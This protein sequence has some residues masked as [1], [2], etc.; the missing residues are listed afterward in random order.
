MN[1][2][3]EKFGW[4]Y[5]EDNKFGMIQ[6]FWY[7]WYILKKSFIKSLYIGFNKYKLRRIYK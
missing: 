3:I 4:K 7:N 2:Y 1:K 6:E 5:L